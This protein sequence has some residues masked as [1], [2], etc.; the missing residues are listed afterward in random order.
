MPPQDDG[1][2]L[3]ATLI[4]GRANYLGI[5]MIA[6][7]DEIKWRPED[8]PPPDLIWNIHRHKC[9]LLAI[10][11]ARDPEIYEGMG[12]ELLL[13]LIEQPWRTWPAG[14]EHWPV[15][16]FVYRL[17]AEQYFASLSDE[18]APGE[19]KGI[20]LVGG[21]IRYF[22]SVWVNIRVLRRRGC[23]LPVEL[24]HLGR[25]EIGPKMEKILEPFGVRCVSAEQSERQ[26]PAR[27]LN[28]WELKSYAL[29]NSRFRE[30]VYLD[31]DN[32]VLINPDTIFTWPQYRD[33]GA[34]LWPDGTGMDPWPPDS[35][36]WEVASVPYRHEFQVE[37]GQLVID[38]ARCTKALRMV[39]WYD[40]HSDYFYRFWWGDKESFHFGFRKAGKPYSMTSKPNQALQCCICQ[41]D[42]D[43]RRIFQHRVGDKWRLAEGNLRV[44]GFVDEELCFGFLA[45][46]RA[47]WNGAIE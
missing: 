25:H 46:L 7:G 17:A 1:S 38:K 37:A 29:L 41:H 20:V 34:V 6:D 23:S 35:P 3:T 30:I 42:F 26:R 14:W 12:A 33:V 27:V 13:K 21:G 19:G 16:R 4:L 5:T 24:W 22:P 15:T 44:A 8:R 40:Q 36:V 39:H 11:A 28:G 31:A 43:G 10:L 47:R 18:P 2:K 9:A 32:H 45:E